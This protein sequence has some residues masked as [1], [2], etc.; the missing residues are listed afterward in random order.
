MSS[1]HSAL[2]PFTI[3]GFYLL[4]WGTTLGANVWNTVVSAASARRG[5]NN[6]ISDQCDV[7]EPRSM[8]RAVD[9]SRAEQISI[10]HRVT[11]R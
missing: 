11:S 6:A 8:E 1:S 4:T 5:N 10:V 3:K 7:V 9:Q 2:A